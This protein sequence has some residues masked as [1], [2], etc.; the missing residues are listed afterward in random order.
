VVYHDGQF[1]DARLNINLIQTAVER[2]AVALNYAPA[3]GLTRGPGGAI[4]G[5]IVRDAEGGSEWRAA[6]RVVVNAGGPFCDDVRRLADPGAAP[7]VAASQGSHV[8][9]DRSFLPGA[10]ALL[11]PETPDGRVLFAIPWHGHTLVGTTDIEVPTAP[12]DPRATSE[13]IDFI[14]ETAGRYLARRPQRT[15]VLSTFAG[16]RPL[17]KVGSSSTAA[18]SRDH[19]VRVDAPGLVT[20]TGGKWTTYRRMAEDGVTRAAALAGLPKRACRTRELP[21]HGHEP[22]AARFGDLAG[23]GSDAPAIQQ[24][25]DADTT[26]GERLHAALPYRAAEALWAV[27]MEM[28]RTVE[29]VL[30]RRLRALFLNA[31]AVVEMAPRV[32]IMMA[33]ELGRDEAWAAEQVSAFQ[34]L[35]DGYRV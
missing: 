2:G 27:R 9:L 26:L 20:I 8:V 32:A 3:V 10:S 29:D 30:A 23:Y 7:L 19:T 16:I 12:L 17:V 1:D 22:D 5:V 31:A 28:A 35:A 24:L 18:L 14:L 11:V 4:D 6:A 15:D 34:R 33:R 21:I 13:E 25:I